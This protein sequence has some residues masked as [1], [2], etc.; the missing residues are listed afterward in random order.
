MTKENLNDAEILTV[1][2]QTR[3]NHGVLLQALREML[4]AA[5]AETTVEGQRRNEIINLT[6]GD[7]AKDPRLLQ[8]LRE[9][10]AFASGKGELTEARGEQIYELAN[11]DLPI[12]SILA[13][14]EN[15]SDAD[16][17]EFLMEAFDMRRVEAVEHVKRREYLQRYLMPVR[18][19]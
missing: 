18:T 6:I 17:T 12:E 4:H 10:V 3:I 7:A 16:L 8:A 19:R 14:D 9:L 1:A 15:S 2:E 11:S 5:N 13:N